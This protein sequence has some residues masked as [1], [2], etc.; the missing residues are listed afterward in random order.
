[1]SELQI[2]SAS[3]GEAAKI[4]GNGARPIINEKTG[5][6]LFDQ[7]TGQ[8][9]IMTSRGLVVNSALRKDEWEELDRAIVQAAVAP[10]NM[11]QRMIAAG[12]TRPLGGL[13]TLIAQYN[14]ISEMTQANVSLS[15]NASGQKD[16]VDYDLVGVP[17]PVIF[18]EF[19]LNQR[20][21]EA[22][23]RLGD[24]IDT[25]NGAAAARVV[26]EKVE[27][28]LINGDASVNLNGNTIHGLTSHPD[29]NTNTATALGG[30]DFAT[31][32]NIMPTFSGILSELKAD[33]YRGPYGV[34]VADTQ[35]DQMAFNVYSDGSGQSALNR[36][37]QIPSIQFID[38]SAW[39]DAG[40]IVVVN[41]SRDVV[42]LA[43]VQQ[44]WPITNLEWTSGDG[45]QSNFKVMTVFAP[46]VKSDY[47]GRSGVFHC[48]GA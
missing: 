35:Y 25:A 37:L 10:L 38:S 1:M 33:N 46:M 47:S 7:R 22:S 27:D 15:G 29:R 4:L 17:V 5:Q 39:L 31:I 13:G 11:T 36:V 19:E 23:R 30:G 26:G 14:Q 18:K 40:E 12:L 20:Y 28:L 3:S 45:M 6:P 21:L 8:L 48:T 16:R 43:Y 24:S 2:V 42:E 41:L 32:S 9:Q 44:Y 34:F